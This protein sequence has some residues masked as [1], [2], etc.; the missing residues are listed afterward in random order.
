[1]G[2]GWEIFTHLDLRH[3]F[4]LFQTR[5][6]KAFVLIMLHFRN[7]GRICDRVVVFFVLSSLLRE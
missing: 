1:M 6:V 5:L 3:L 7:D 2:Q 4:V